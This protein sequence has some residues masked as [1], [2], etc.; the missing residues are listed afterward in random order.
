MESNNQNKELQELRTEITNHINKV[1]QRLRMAESH[2]ENR[3]TQ[4]RYDIAIFKRKHAEVPDVIKKMINFES[5]L[6]KQI[7]KLEQK[8]NNNYPL[9]NE[10]IRVAVKLWFEDRKKCIKKYG[11]ISD[12]NTSNVT[13]MSK[14]F[15]GLRHFDDDINNWDVS[16]V[17][18]MFQMFY[19]CRT[20]NQP[21]N[22]WDVSNVQDFT[23]MFYRCRL[24]RQ[25]LD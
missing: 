4:M 6:Q 5:E 16:N 20:F 9:D 2:F 23:F 8:M 7:T 21:L 10:T 3:L 24:F 18:D 11:R 1:E 12:W 13:D 17:T 19:D 22:K 14:L 15:K 25:P